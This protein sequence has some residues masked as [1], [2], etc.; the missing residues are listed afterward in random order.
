[1][2]VQPSLAVEAL[3]WAATATFVGS[4]LFTRSEH[5]VRAQLAGGVLWVIYGALLAANVL[6]VCAAAWKAWRPGAVR[7]HAGSGRLETSAGSDA[8]PSA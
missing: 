7:A 2:T 6:V 5:L 3:G 1:V 8:A 4:Y